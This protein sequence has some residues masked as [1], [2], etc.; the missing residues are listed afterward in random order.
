MPSFGQALGAEFWTGLRGS[1]VL[2][3]IND[4]ILECWTRVTGDWLGL[5]YWK[6]V[7]KGWL[8]DLEERKM[9]S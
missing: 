5:G 1:G 2:K 3:R 6:G 4:V 9:I 7:E 8:H